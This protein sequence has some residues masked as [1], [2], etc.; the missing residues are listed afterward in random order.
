VLTGHTL[1][2][3]AFKLW[4]GQDLSELK[5]KRRHLKVVNLRHV[6][7]GSF[8][9]L[10]SSFWSGQDLS[11]PKVKKTFERCSPTVNH[12]LTGT[13]FL[14]AQ[15]KDDILKLLTGTTSYLESPF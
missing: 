6:L 13:P 14:R 5:V 10:I 4:S 8:P 15:G 2:N 7:K 1:S 11:E 3:S 9:T 12:V